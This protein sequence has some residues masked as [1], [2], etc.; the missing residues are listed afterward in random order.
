MPT[1]NDSVVIR[2][3]RIEENSIVRGD[4]RGNKQIEMIVLSIGFPVEGEHCLY[5]ESVASSFERFI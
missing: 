1:A 5:A 3:G 4:S 2:L